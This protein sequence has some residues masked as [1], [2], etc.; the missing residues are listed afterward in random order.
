MPS[1]RHVCHTQNSQCKQQ[2]ANWPADAHG[3]NVSQTSW[4]DEL[5][6]G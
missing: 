3:T 4:E 5:E 2:S 1:L 6:R